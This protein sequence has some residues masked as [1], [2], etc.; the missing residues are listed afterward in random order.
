M[1]HI[2]C[3]LEQIGEETCAP[4]S[5]TLLTN[6]VTALAGS[7]SSSTISNYVS[8]IQAWHILHRLKWEIEDDI[9][10][11][12]LRGAQQAAPESSKK[13][14]CLPFTP[15]IISTLHAQLNLTK[16]AHVAVYAC[17]T[18]AFYSTAHLRELTV[19]NLGAFHPSTH[20]WQADVHT[21]TD[22][23]GLTSTVVHLPHSK[24]SPI[25]AGEDIYWSS[26]TGITDLEATFNR[27]L[28]VASAPLLIETSW[29]P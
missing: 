14:K 6:F 21:V 23:Q 3:D 18:A 11:V 28:Q 13:A 5:S 26:Q 20:P 4:I 27:H 2:Y 22:H 9:L 12:L 19:E 24:A 17:L 16:H 7:Y 10:E 29:T 8:S 15:T 1:Y 25:S